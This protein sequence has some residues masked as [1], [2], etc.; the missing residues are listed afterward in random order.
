MILKDSTRE[1]IGG[2]DK[3]LTSI[4]IFTEKIIRNKHKSQDK[5][6]GIKKEGGNYYGKGER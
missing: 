3:I 4:Q 5:I 6:T 1:G 2:Q